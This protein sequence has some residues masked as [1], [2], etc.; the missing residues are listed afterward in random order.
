MRILI[1][2]GTEVINVVLAN[3]VPRGGIISDTGNIG[4]TVR[5]VNGQIVIVPKSVDNS[6]DLKVEAQAALTK[7]DIVVIRC[8]EKGISVPAAWSIYRA[9]LRSVVTNGI[10]PLPAQ[11]DYPV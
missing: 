10:G 7:S 6:V 5:K 1:L 8:L 11:P 3:K 4:D 9:D 2:D